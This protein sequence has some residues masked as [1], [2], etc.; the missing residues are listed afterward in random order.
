MA[1]YKLMTPEGTKDYLF[2]EVVARNFVID[3]LQSLFTTSGY[4]EVCTPAIEYLDVFEK[5][6]GIPCEQMYKL[7]DHEGRLMVLR[8]DSTTPIA[9]VVATRLKAEHTPIRLFYHQSVFSTTRKMS[10]KSDEILQSGIELISNSCFK[11]D[12]EVL[13]LAIR[14]LATFSPYSF[15]LEIGHIGIFNHLI[16]QLSAEDSQ[17][18]E[19]RLLIKS[20]NYPA[21]NDLLDHIGDSYEAT[22]LKQLP[23]LF[24]G[25]EVFDKALDVL[26][27]DTT[28]AILKELKNVYTNLE[29]LQTDGD[30]CVDLGIVNRTN[31]YTGI[32]FEGY[33]EDF[34]GQ[35]VLV[36]GR[37]D[38]LT[39]QFTE[40]NSGFGATGFAVNVDAAALALLETNLF[41]G[42]NPVKILVHAIEGYE[43]EALN[44]MK[45][46]SC[47]EKINVEFSL[48]DNVEDCIKYAEEKDINNVYAVSDKIEKIVG[49]EY[50]LK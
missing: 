37:Y 45:L 31:Y 30:I 50:K 27:D 41:K 12:M 2:D 7:S 17:K 6:S 3:K 5:E 25:V 38:S 11:A 35:A 22:A 42:V 47:D 8:P 32:V 16:E 19:I 4:C 21:L 15:R 10:G 14:S 18:E 36:G 9:R 23:T 49:F 46:I 44:Y 33:M 48:F 29:K 26:K 43:V 39:A 13:A 28:I 1:V 24:G 20:K 40:D 34:L